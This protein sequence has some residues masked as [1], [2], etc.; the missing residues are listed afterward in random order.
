VAAD[1]S[2]SLVEVARHGSKDDCWML[3]AGQVYDLT[4]Y[5]PQ[6]PSDPTAFLPWCGK[7]ATEAYR[8]KTEGRPHSPYADQLLAKYRIGI[9]EERRQ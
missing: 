8:T 9:V 6:H 4:T 7:E 3:I 1:K 5:V 2:Y